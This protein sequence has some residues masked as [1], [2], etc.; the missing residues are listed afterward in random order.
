MKN[1]GYNI[2]LDI[3]AKGYYVDELYQAVFVNNAIFSGKFFEKWFD[4]A[5]IDNFFIHGSAKVAMGLS[6]IFS[7]MQSGRVSGYLLSLVVGTLLVLYFL[8]V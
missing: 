6:G 7:L 5:V 4:K 8:L 1:R 3:L 2:L